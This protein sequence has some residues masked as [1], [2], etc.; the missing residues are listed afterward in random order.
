VRHCDESYDHIVL[1]GGLL[2]GLLVAAGL[3]R[4]PDRRQGPAQ[5]RRAAL[6]LLGSLAVASLATVLAGFD[7]NE[8]RGDELRATL[9]QRTERVLDCL[10]RLRVH[11]PNR[12]GFPIVE[13]PLRD[14]NRIGA[15][16]QMLFDRGVYATL[17][18]YPLVPKTRSGSA[19]S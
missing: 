4:L 12:S 5:G 18:A 8:T 2:E 10:A 16:G 14:Y 19:S 15:V 13:I 3:H 1:V 9:C 11:T 7:V 17:A 6:P